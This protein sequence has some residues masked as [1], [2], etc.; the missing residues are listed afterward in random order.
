MLSY[1]TSESVLNTSD[2]HLI[3][4]ISSFAPGYHG[5]SKQ[6]E[7]MATRGAGIVIYSSVV[8]TATFA[9]KNEHLIFIYVYRL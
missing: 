4:I 3:H 5:S 2:F 7:A 8:K 6:Q 1:T 9:I